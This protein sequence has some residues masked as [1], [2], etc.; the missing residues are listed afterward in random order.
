[1]QLEAL[2]LALLSAASD[3]QAVVAVDRCDDGSPAAQVRQLREELSR[4]LG[5]A[6]Q[7]EDETAEAL[8]GVQRGSRA[9]IE[10]LIASARFDIF[11]QQAYDRAERTLKTALEDVWRLPPTESRWRDIRDVRMMLARVYTRLGKKPEADALIEGILRVEP[12]FKPDPILYAPSS[13][14][15]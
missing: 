13:G 15:T 11:H 12:D 2:V 7:S 6:V 1:M 4:R 8:G 14:R 10:R 3:R 9:E 5:A